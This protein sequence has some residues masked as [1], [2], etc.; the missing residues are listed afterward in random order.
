VRFIV[1][2]HLPMFP[3]AAPRRAA[4]LGLEPAGR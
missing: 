2:P 3:F 4:A 1:F